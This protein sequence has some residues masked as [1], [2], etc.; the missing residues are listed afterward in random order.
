MKSKSKTEF[1]FLSHNY[2]WLGLGT[3]TTNQSS[4][5]SSVVQVRRADFLEKFPE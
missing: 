3:A 2:D 4:Q 1:V 5:L